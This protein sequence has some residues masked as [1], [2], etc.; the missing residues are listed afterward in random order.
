MTPTTGK[1]ALAYTDL[2]LTYCPAC[3]AELDLLSET[4]MPPNWLPFGPIDDPDDLPQKQC[5]RCEAF[6]AE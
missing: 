3:T 6:L 2:V 1:P 4:T 5:D